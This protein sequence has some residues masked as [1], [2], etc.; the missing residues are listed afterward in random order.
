MGALM[1]LTTRARDEKAMSSYK[2]ARVFNSSEARLNNIGSISC[3]WYLDSVPP[4]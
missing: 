4:V 3:S 2:V 1:Y